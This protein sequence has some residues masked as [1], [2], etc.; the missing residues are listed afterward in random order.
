MAEKAAPIVGLIPGVGTL[1]GGAIG[2]LGALAAGDGLSGALKYGLEGAA[3]GLGGGLL[4]GSGA[5]GSVASLGADSAVPDAAMSVAGPAIVG[6][7]SEAAAGGGGFLGSLEGLAGN[8][9]RFLTGNGGKNAIGAASAL[10]SYLNQQKANNYAKE[11]LGNV[12]DAYN[13]K[14]PLRAQGLATLAGAQ[15]GNPYAGGA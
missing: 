8:A 3:S 5:L 4:K 13:Q 9:G 11:A 2:G 10:S 15:R 1:A 6:G 12:E 14:A 7:P